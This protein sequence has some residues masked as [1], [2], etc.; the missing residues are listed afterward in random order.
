MNKTTLY[1]REEGPISYELPIFY[2]RRLN[3]ERFAE[4]ISSGMDW[5]WW[6][7]QP[8]P[9]NDQP[10]VKDLPKWRPP[11]RL[12]AE[13]ISVLVDDFRERNV[14]GYGRFIGLIGTSPD[15]QL[16]ISTEADVR[17][18][19]SKFVQ[20]TGSS[21]Q[22]VIT[23]IDDSAAEHIF[24]PQH[25]ADSVKRVGKLG[26]TAIACQEST[27]QTTALGEA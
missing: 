1:F 25:P 6:S 10:I 24:V 18:A 27:L 3:I 23:H 5:Y 15:R 2:D 9:L 14:D 13:N 4:L 8:R 26:Y 20:D 11:T 7:Y 17:T 22:I 21:S 16:V 19:L 12:T